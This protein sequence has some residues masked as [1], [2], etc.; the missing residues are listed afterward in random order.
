MRNLEQFFDREVLNN[1]AAKIFDPL[2][3]E[4][5]ALKTIRSICKSD[6]TVCTE[7]LNRKIRAIINA[8]PINRNK[9]TDT[10]LNMSLRARARNQRRFYHLM[11]NFLL[12]NTYKSVE[13]HTD[14]NIIHTKDNFRIYFF[15]IFGLT[16]E[17]V[18]GDDTPET[19]IW[20]EVNRLCNYYNPRWN[21]WLNGESFDD[22]TEET[23]TTQDNS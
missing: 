15:K 21:R 22:S 20:G 23:Q 17:K 18:K 12:G 5:Q 9:H 14:W 10:S 3:G 8:H 6:G 2:S 13:E 1:I 11:R 16:F 7:K 19:P 4:D